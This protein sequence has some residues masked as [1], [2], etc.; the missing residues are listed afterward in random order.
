MIG[1][2]GD[3]IL[4]G[5]S[6]QSTQPVILRHTNSDGAP[7]NGYES[8]D[9]A[10]HQSRRQGNNDLSHIFLLIVACLVGGVIGGIGAVVIASYLF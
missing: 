5:S 6:N 10:T 9:K 2:L 3:G 7:I 4:Y 1:N 8:T